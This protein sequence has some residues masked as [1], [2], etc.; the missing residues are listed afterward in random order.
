ML[1]VLASLP[2]A[3]LMALTLFSFMS[4]MVDSGAQSKSEESASLSY[5]LVMVE[6]D[7]ETV[8]RQRVL[9]EPP[10]MP[11]TPPSASAVEHSAD[12]SSVQTLTTPQLPNI[13]ISTQV[14]GVSLNA[15]SVPDIGQNQ[16]VMPLH[17][18]QPKYPRRALQRNI[19]GYVVMSFTIDETGR[20]TDIEVIDA[21]P[22][23]LFDREAKVALKQWKY[24]PMIVNGKAT[25]RVGQT[26]T[27]EFKLNQ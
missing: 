15:P 26:V 9:P 3:A 10:K 2:L 21:N 18:K 4:W 1:R 24:Q 16:Q 5:D 8:R 7:S 13:A 25:S 27:L 11:V 14:T 17:R 19:E 12:V 23:R 6:P 20:P 22:K